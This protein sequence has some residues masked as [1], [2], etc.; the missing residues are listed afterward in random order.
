MWDFY[1]W[2]YLQ[3]CVVLWMDFVRSFKSPLSFS[4]LRAS[5]PGL[6]K[7]IPLARLTKGHM[8]TLV[9]APVPWSIMSIGNI[10]FYWY[11]LLFQHLGITLTGVCAPPLIIYNGWNPGCSCTFLAPVAT[12]FASCLVST[13]W[14]FF[15]G[16]QPLI[17]LISCGCLSVELVEIFTPF[18]YGFKSFLKTKAQ[19]EFEL[20]TCNLLPWSPQSFDAGIWNLAWEVTSAISTKQLMWRISASHAFNVV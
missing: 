2:T 16:W 8:S 15:S 3:C 9:T 18:L 19:M 14:C 7:L 5:N 12:P 4:A 6:N 20:K 17:S 11:P 10:V 13:W 1:I